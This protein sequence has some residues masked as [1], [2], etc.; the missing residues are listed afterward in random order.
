MMGLTM[1]KNC[2][3]TARYKT[4]SWIIFNLSLPCMNPAC[5]LLSYP[6][7]WMIKGEHRKVLIFFTHPKIANT[8]SQWLGLKHLPQPLRTNSKSFGTLRQLLNLKKNKNKKQP[9]GFR[10]GGPEFF[11]G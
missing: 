8:F 10:E 9:Q 7:G 2:V 1:Y 5:S 3:T 6:Q 11:W 4:D